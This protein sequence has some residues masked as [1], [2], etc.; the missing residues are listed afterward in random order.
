MDYTLYDDTKKKSFRK[1]I[2]IVRVSDEEE[3]TIGRTQTNTIKLKDISVSRMHCYLLKK[4]NKIYVADKGSK[5]GTLLYLNKP[6]TLST[7]VNNLNKTNN[8]FI[9]STTNLIS[10]KNHFNLKITQNWNI[11]SNLFSSTFCCKCKSTND[12]EFI[13]NM[14]DLEENELTKI[15]DNANLLN[16]SYCDYILNLETII[17]HDESNNNNSFI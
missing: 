8:P 3:I 14:D 15:K 4:N 12:E 11:F 1:G 16:D 2:I 5:F 6:F 9:D 10:G 13:L 17:K 7:S